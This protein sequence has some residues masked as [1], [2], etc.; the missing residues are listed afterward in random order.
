[1]QVTAKHFLM[2]LVLAIVW[3]SSFTAVKVAVDD[4]TPVQIAFIRVLIGAILVLAVALFS[5]INLPKKLVNW[6]LL[7]LIALFSNVIPFSLIGWASTR[8]DSST[9]SIL[10]STSPIFALV[11]AHFFTSDDRFTLFKL[12]SVLLGFTGV[13]VLSFPSESSLGSGEL[14]PKI[15]TL[16]AA[17][18]YVIAGMLPRRLSENLG[19]PSITCTV[20]C[21][22]SIMLAPIAITQNFSAIDS[23]SSEALFAVL[24]LGVFSTALALMI[25]YS[26]ILQV[27]YTFVSYT[28]FLVPVFAVIFGAILLREELGNHAYIALSLVL[29]ALAVS[30]LSTEKLA[31][32]VS[33]IR[34]SKTE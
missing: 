34:G 5:K 19:V 8:S 27:G 11:V 28:G 1:M 10:M 20:L 16:L 17:L 9:V 22:S 23:Y 32:Y 26:L 4:F 2:I 13:V 3:G 30:R 7:L 12:L 14:L 33:T 15:A 21:L 25:R 29:A 24:Y 18:S 6:V 31:G